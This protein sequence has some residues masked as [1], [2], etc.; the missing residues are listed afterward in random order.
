MNLRDPVPGWLTPAQVEECTRAA[1]IMIQHWHD[2]KATHREGWNPSPEQEL[3]V[4]TQGLFAEAATAN[5]LGWL[6]HPGI[7]RHHERGDI[8]VDTDV[9][10]G[11]KHG[12]RHV[13]RPTDP[14]HH[15]SI[16]TT[17][18][19]PKRGFLIWGGHQTGHLKRVG[20]L[21]VLGNA[22]GPVYVVC[23]QQLE[24]IRTQLTG[25]QIK[26]A[27]SRAWDE[28]A[29]L[30]GAERLPEAAPDHAALYGLPGPGG[31]RLGL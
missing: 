7:D 28:A 12:F 9:H 1:L 16:H 4:M 18:R 14:D 3:D 24:P 17:G 6:Y 25:Q 21:Q 15:F 11:D 26:H 13:V 10:R 20:R 23:K 2:R 31:W 27:I 22:P 19:W 8:A 29:G 5:C 30:F